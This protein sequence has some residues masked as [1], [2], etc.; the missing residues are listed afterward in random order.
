MY[1]SSPALFDLA[2]DL[3][4]STSRGD[5]RTYVHTFCTVRTA[6]RCRS[7]PSCRGTP[8]TPLWRDYSF[9]A[10][11]NTPCP[12]AYTCG[13]CGD[14]NKES[15]HNTKSI[16]NS[17]NTKQ[18]TFLSLGGPGARG[19]GGRGSRLR[20]APL[21]FLGGFAFYALATVLD[22]QLARALVATRGL[23]DVAPLARPIGALRVKL[24]LEAR[25]LET[26]ASTHTTT[27]VRQSCGRAS[28]PQKELYFF[29][30]SQRE[31]EPTGREGTAVGMSCQK[32]YCTFPTM[33]SC[34]S[35]RP[36][37]TYFAHALYGL[38]RIDGNLSDNYIPA[39]TQHA[40]R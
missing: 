22:A 13:T 8:G 23:L 29:A 12:S 26:S 9:S 10:V 32:G 16:Q 38:L 18:N 3:S 24:A 21:G 37:I 33:S 34:S 6:A 36:C 2:C 31:D 28:S 19:G 25:F 39:G 40:G 1:L 30:R 11:V 14:E 20:G 15:T 35:P 17:K 5:S 7:W 4:F 27:R